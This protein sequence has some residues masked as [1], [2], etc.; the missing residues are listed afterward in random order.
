M[1]ILAEVRDYFAMGGFAREHST[2]DL[3]F[4][5]HFSLLLCFRES[6]L[7]GYF[8]EFSGFA[9]LHRE[10]ALQVYSEQPRRAAS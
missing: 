9:R 10:T 5:L 7:Q 2:V 4:L 1:D 3:R 8:V 6:C